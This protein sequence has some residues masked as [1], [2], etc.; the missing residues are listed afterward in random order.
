MRR[1]H[2][3]RALHAILRTFAPSGGRGPDDAGKFTFYDDRRALGGQHHHRGLFLRKR[4]LGQGQPAQIIWAMIIIPGLVV[5]CAWKAA[6]ACLGAHEF[7]DQRIIFARMLLVPVGW[8][9]PGSA[10]AVLGQHRRITP[11]S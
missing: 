11:A 5:L 6:R 2:R 1:H 8:S 3:G 9:H 10:G 4:S 7:I